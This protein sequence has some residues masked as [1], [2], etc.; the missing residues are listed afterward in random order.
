MKQK[1]ISELEQQVMNIIWERKVCSVK[2]IYTELQKK[3]KIAYT[4]V[5]TIVLRLEKKG[6][7]K[8]KGEERL[9]YIYQPALSKETYTKSIAKAFLKRF[10]QS[11][12]D[13]AVAS[14]AESVEKLPEKKRK[15]F[16]KLLDNYDSSK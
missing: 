16:L 3:R 4:T 1:P 10:I 8:K 14:F 9:S 15:Y 7:V 2:D 12:G 6:L 13:T 11:F 5:A